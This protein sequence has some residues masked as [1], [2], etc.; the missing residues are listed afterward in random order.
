MRTEKEIRRMLENIEES[1]PDIENSSIG[2]NPM[3]AYHYGVYAGLKSA[4][5]EYE[6]FA[7]LDLEEFINSTFN[8][9]EPLSI[10]NQ[11][12]RREPQ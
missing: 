3:K 7:E 6:S 4:L 2:Y 9:F 5:G 10:I 8:Q 12:V 1:Y 11:E